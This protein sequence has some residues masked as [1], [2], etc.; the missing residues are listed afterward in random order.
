MATPNGCSCGMDALAKAWNKYVRRAG[1]NRRLAFTGCCDEHDLFY[2]QGGSRAD[3]AGPVCRQGQGCP[4]RLSDEIGF[5][6]F[7]CAPQ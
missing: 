2:A 1:D 3:R 7:S 4:C 6:A 5:R